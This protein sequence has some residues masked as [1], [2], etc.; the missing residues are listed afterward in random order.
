[1]SLNMVRVNVF[2]TSRFDFDNKVKFRSMMLHLVK[3][4]SLT[5]DVINDLNKIIELEDIMDD[6]VSEAMKLITKAYNDNK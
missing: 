6:P 1:M 4:K 2:I 5:D 3:N